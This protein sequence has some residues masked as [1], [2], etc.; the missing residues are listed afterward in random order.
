MEW[1][2]ILKHDINKSTFMYNSA[3]R[4]ENKNFR[5]VGEVEFVV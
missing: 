3:M 4:N 2:D 5:N 1:C